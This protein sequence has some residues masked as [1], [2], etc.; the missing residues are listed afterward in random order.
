MTHCESVDGHFDRV[1]SDHLVLRR[2]QEAAVVGGAAARV[3][4]TRPYSPRQ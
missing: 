1:L 2:L 3:M 4:R